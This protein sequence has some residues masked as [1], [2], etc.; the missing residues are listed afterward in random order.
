MRGAA[1]LACAA[2]LAGCGGGGGG[3]GSN[4]STIKIS[5]E[6]CFFSYSAQA[7]SAGSGADPLLDRQWHLRNQGQEGGR[8][9]EDVRA[10]DA[11]ELGTKGEGVRVAIVDDAIETLHEDLFPNVA[12]FRNY[13]RGVDA[14]SH[15]L[16]C[17]ADDTHGTAVAGIA[18]A[19]DGNGVGVA[20]VAPRVKLAAY[21]ALATG[22][23]ADISDALL[24]ENEITGVYNN[25]WG[26][27]DQTGA[28]NASGTTFRTA[29]LDGIAN[30]RGGKGSVYVF[31]AGNGGC[32]P[33]AVD[34]D[35][36]NSNFDGFVNARGVLAACAVGDDGRA[37]WYAEPGANILVCGMS[38]RGVTSG[39][40]ITTTDVQNRYRADF[41]G[42]SASTPMVSGVAALI[43]QANP[44]L[45]WRDVRLILARTARRNDDTGWQTNAAGRPIHPKY[46][47]G[48]ANASAAVDAAKAATTI[49]GSESL[50]SCSQ[51]R[52]PG[53]SLLDGVLVTDTITFGAE[54]P[55][56]QI[57]LV[58]I[59]FRA[60]HSYSG[61]LQI[62]LQRRSPASPDTLLAN[63]RECRAHDGARISCGSYDD[64]DGWIFTSVR[65]LDEPAQ[66]SWT[67][68][69]H[70]RRA[71]DQG[72]WTQWSL[73]IWGR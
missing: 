52:S 57:E 11:W 58:E 8:A 9:G 30:G 28:L 36:D 71:G 55:I 21:N 61:D 67:L 35:P 45:T 27:T 54:C 65:N 4:T 22:T 26:S 44:A 73:T 7:P 14:D 34:C 41:S 24:R 25:S 23:E 40:A 70:D 46:G 37:P 48:I 6:G 13:R 1:A 68:S 38:D 18:A 63:A 3:D 43:L 5:Q 19:R 59:G 51:T 56:S 10:L 15:P 33:T 72:T 49:G 31:P 60:T 12:A 64:D 50:R 66:G 17:A 20:G 69:V 42:T 2:L 62:E 32:P 16:P 53:T 29:I 39:A 47:F